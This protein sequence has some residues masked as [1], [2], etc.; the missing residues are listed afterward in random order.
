[1]ITKLVKGLKSTTNVNTDLSLKLK[2]NFY[3]VPKASSKMYISKINRIT[4]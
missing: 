3:K 4:K 1:M 2:L